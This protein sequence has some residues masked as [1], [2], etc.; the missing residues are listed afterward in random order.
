M[1]VSRRDL[2]RII[3]SIL[4]EGEKE[5]FS[6]KY[7][8]G[9]WLENL[10][11]PL[12]FDYYIDVF[13]NCSNF[14]DDMSKYFL[15]NSFYSKKSQFESDLKRHTGKILM[16]TDN[17]KQYD[18]TSDPITL[19]WKEDDSRRFKKHPSHG[20]DRGIWVSTYS[21]I[22][23][24]SIEIYQI[25]GFN[26]IKEFPDDA[27]DYEIE[28]NRI[29]KPGSIIKMRLDI[30]LDRILNVRSLQV[31]LEGVGHQTIN[32]TGPFYEKIISMN[33]EIV[34]DPRGP[35]AY[36][37]NIALHALVMTSIPGSSLFEIIR[38]L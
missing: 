12:G 38:G 22:F 23:D 1:I 24:K 37:S 13:Y 4:L 35:L 16:L 36:P 8:P 19:T 25:K 18:F 9:E 31:K 30:I 33:P 10:D 26:K 11:K 3:K 2:Q 32:K 28:M 20:N 6:F 7:G 21:T 15:E 29:D 34:K 27:Y 17:I 14:Y 5:D